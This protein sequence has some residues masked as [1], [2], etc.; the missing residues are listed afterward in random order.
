MGSMSGSGQS[1]PNWPPAHVRSSPVSDRTADIGG[2]PVRA[3]RRHGLQSSNE[4]GRQL[5]RPFFKSCSATVGVFSLAPRATKLAGR[6]CSGDAYPR[7]CLPQSGLV[8]YILCDLF[9]M[10]LL[11]HILATS[12]FGVLP[13][14]KRRRNISVIWRQV[15]LQH[16]VRNAGADGGNSAPFRN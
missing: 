14:S 5:R 10:A 15:G 7:R 2:G 13:C 16:A 11:S 9:S 6:V 1:R 12:I 3:N 8:Q 4:R